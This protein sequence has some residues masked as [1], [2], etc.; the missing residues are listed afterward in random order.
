MAILLA[1]AGLIFAIIALVLVT[2]A[3]R[4]RPRAYLRWTLMALFGVIVAGMWLLFLL[5][6]I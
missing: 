5:I 3:D 2:I 1:V 6:F 4:A